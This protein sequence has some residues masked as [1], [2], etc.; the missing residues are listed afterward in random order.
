[1]I[2]ASKHV[3]TGKFGSWNIEEGILSLLDQ[4]IERKES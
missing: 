1:M 4:N 3:E 2:F